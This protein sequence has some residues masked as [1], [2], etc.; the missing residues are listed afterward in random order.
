M[1]L[2]VQRL[3]DSELASVEDAELFRA[4]VLSWCVSWH[5]LPAGSLPDDDA[6]L[7]RLLGYGRDLRRWRALRRKGA[8]RGWVRCQDG[9]LYHP[10]VAEKVTQV[11]AK[12]IHQ[13]QRVLTRWQRIRDAQEASPN[14]QP[15][16]KPQNPGCHGITG[17]DEVVIPK[18]EREREGK[19]NYPP[20][21]RKRGEPAAPAPGFAEFWRH[22][23]RKVGK[24]AAERAWGSATKIDPPELIVQ[25]LVIQIDLE[26]FDL[27][28]GGRFCPHAATWLNQ[29]RWQ[30]GIEED[31]EADEQPPPPPPAPPTRLPFDDP[32]D[33][34]D[35]HP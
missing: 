24:G 32:D 31:D 26:R 5:Q 9:R 3:R 2:D 1:P 23:P 30:D 10:V 20:T 21:P 18:K 12:S 28:E 11:A 35:R 17:S 29:K 25:A 15:T 19:R 6:A 27:R 14:D 16:D 22:Y 4:A 7:S 8:L 13:R 33:D 34:K